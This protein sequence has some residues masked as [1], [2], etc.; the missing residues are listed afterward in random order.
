MLP[1]V[2]SVCVT[3]GFRWSCWRTDHLLRLAGGI[4]LARVRA[5]KFVAINAA[6]E[7]R[8][9]DDDHHE[10]AKYHIEH[11]HG[12]VSIKTHHG[13]FLT[14]DHERHVSLSGTTLRASSLPLQANCRAFVAHVVF[15]G[16]VVLSHSRGEPYCEI[17]S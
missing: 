12:K 10:D 13:T 14:I 16:V 6:G 1:R 2:A 11:P 7:V 4:S 15:L 9:L 5:G 17:V 8:L 3:V